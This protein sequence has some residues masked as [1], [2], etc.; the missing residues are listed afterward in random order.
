MIEPSLI[1]FPFFTEENGSLNVYESGKQVPF[2]IRRVFTVTANVND[3]RGEHSHRK[4]SQ[5]LIC[6]SGKIK[7]TCDNGSFVTEYLLENMNDGLLIPPGI[8]ATQQYLDVNSVLLVLCD[9]GYE[10]EDY[11]RNYDEFLAWVKNQK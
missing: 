8:W 5:L 3:I 10:V 6:T 7:I 11:I 1:R 9:R 2:L 4:C